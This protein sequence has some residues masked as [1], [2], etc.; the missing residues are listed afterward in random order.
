MRGTIHEVKATRNDRRAE[1]S[2]ALQ[3]RDEND[4]FRPSFRDAATRRR[5]QKASRSQSSKARPKTEAEIRFPRPC[6]RRL[7]RGRGVILA[8]QRLVGKSFADNLRYRQREPATIIQV[9]PVVVTESLLVDIPE[10]MEWLYAHVCAVQ[11]AFQQTPEVLDCVGVDVP[12]HVFDGV[13]DYVVIVVFGQS[14]VGR[15]FVA[16]DNGASFDVLMDG[17]LEFMSAT[18]I[19]MKGAHAAI[20]FDHAEDNGLVHAASAVNLLRTLVLMHVAGFAADHALIHFYFAAQLAAAFILHGKTDAVEH[21]PCGFL[22]YADGAVE[23]PR[24]NPV[25]VVD[26]HPGSGKPLVQSER[27]ILEDSASLQAELR[28]VVLAVALPNARLFKIGNMVG[29]ATR[30]AHNAIR[31]AKRYHELA[32]VLEVFEEDNRFSKSVSQFH[33]SEDSNP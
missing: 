9:L 24:A 2:S 1:G 3:C 15:Q 5:I 7:E 10:Q 6:R 20:P 19:E 18:A 28:A 27:R 22:S 23:F 25:L 31:P 11:A 4:S 32:A 21:E 26:D 29:V 8:G 33:R 14:I 30:A 12:I 17:L 16:E 13:V